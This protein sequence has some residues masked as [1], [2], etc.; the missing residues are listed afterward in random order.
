MPDGTTDDLDPLDREALERSLALAMADP[1]RRE[2]LQSKLTGDQF[3]QP[4]PWFDVA[5]FAST[6]QQRKSLA[7]APWQWPPCEVEEDEN[8][9]HPDERDAQ[10]LLRQMLRAGLSRFEPDPLAALAKAKTNKP[11]HDRVKPE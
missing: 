6:V 1:E 3:S 7:L 11:K 5:L 2:Q 9:T 8:Y 10:R 4:E